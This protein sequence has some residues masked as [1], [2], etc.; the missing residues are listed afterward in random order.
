VRDGHQG[1]WNSYGFKVYGNV[2]THFIM[3]KIQRPQD[4]LHVAGIDRAE[5][6]LDELISTTHEL[7]FCQADL[8]AGLGFLRILIRRLGE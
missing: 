8:I 7:I 4:P 3:T 6:I 1:E 5:D 2:P